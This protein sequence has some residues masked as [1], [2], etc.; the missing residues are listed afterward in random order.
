MFL[1]HACPPSH[2]PYPTR[3]PTP[4]HP[5]AT[6]PKHSRPADLVR[7]AM[8]LV[9]AVVYGI[10]YLGE[11]RLDPEGVEVAT[12]QNIM[13]EWLGGWVGEWVCGSLGVEVRGW[14]DG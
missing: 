9:V 3:T 4:T 7:L 10:T 11:G 1:A 2:P 13:G 8:S 6:H 14:M 5:P 12:V